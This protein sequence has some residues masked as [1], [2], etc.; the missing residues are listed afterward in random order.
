[1]EQLWGYW[2]LVA[3]STSASSSES[4]SY[5]GS[6]GYYTW[7]VESYAGSGDYEFGLTRP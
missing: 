2:A 4:I 1:M 7:I 6:A 3:S 5:N